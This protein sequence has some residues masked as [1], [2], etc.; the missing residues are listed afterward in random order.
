VTSVGPL[1]VEQL[2]SLQQ[3]GLRM[4]VYGVEV[5]NS[6]RGSTSV[7]TVDIAFSNG[8][9]YSGAYVA[10][11]PQL[12]FRLDG[13]TEQSWHF[14]AHLVNSLAVAWEQT[15]PTGSPHVI[16]GRVRVAGRAKPILSKNGIRV[17]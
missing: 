4:P 8:A 6:G 13:E 11:S 1:T 3:Q 14:D 9:A 10:G 17:L 2:N 12:P 7:T 5:V 15:Q 16:R